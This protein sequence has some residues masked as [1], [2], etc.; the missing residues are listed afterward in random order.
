MACFTE[1]SLVSVKHSFWLKEDNPIARHTKA[2]SCALVVRVACPMP[3]TALHG[4]WRGSQSPRDAG[5]PCCFQL[6]F[7]LSV[8]TG[9]KIFSPGTL[10]LDRITQNVLLTEV[11]C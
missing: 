9:M 10:C 6:P 5:L 7:C 11:T 8:K 4:G 1:L 3:H 2:M